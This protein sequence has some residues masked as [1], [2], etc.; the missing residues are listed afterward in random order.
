MLSN[1]FLLHFPLGTSSSSFHLDAA[2]T[3]LCN[4]FLRYLAHSSNMSTGPSLSLTPVLDTPEGSLPVLAQSVT[5][6]TSEL[7]DELRI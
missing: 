3:R 4:T 6:V 2:A 5:V 7:D 1:L